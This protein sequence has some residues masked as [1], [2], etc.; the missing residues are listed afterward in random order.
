MKSEYQCSQRINGPFDFPSIRD[1]KVIIFL[2]AYGSG[3][4]EVAVNTALLMAQENPDPETEIVLADL[5]IINPF[6]R[7]F[8]AAKILACGNV[9]IIASQFANTNVEAPSVP[10]EVSSVFDRRNVRSVLD[11][12]GEDLGARIVSVLKEKI[13]DTSYELLM[14]VNLNRPFTGT[15]PLIVKMMHELEEA[16]GLK[17]TGMVNNTNLLEM[18]EP[19]ELTESNV[20]L[21]EVTGITGVPVVFAC[22]ADDL[23]PKDWGDRMPDGLPFL[24]LIRT[25]RYIDQGG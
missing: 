12:G 14:V 9:K 5:D 24:R 23:Y 18:T 13:A 21:K 16:A 7:S 22:G 25:I 17:V 20:M 19:A 8:D 2:G 4:S 3:K 15:V 10:G 6:Y 11:I 1:K